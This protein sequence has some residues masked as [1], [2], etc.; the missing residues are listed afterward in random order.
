MKNIPIR[1]I[2]VPFLA[3]NIMLAPAL[4]REP[5]GL[6]HLPPLTV[7]ATPD[8]V[9][10]IN[11]INS[12]SQTFYRDMQSGIHPT[13][14][15]NPTV[16][17]LQR[18][19]TSNCQTP[20]PVRIHNGEK[21]H[22]EVAFT[23]PWEMP[24]NY[25][26]IYYSQ[27]K[28]INI[29]NDLR[30]YLSTTSYGKK[31][32]DNYSV[33]LRDAAI[34]AY[35][36]K[37]QLTRQLPDGSFSP[38][39]ELRSFE[40]VSDPYTMPNGDVE[41]YSI[42]KI[43]NGILMH[44]GIL[45]SRKNLYGIGWEQTTNSA[46][47][48]TS[49]THTNGK[50]IQTKRIDSS[51]TQV[52]DP[53]G[54]NYT[55]KWD[56]ARLTQ[57][58]YPN[59][60]GNKTYHYGENGAGENILTGISID[61]KRFTTYLYNGD[62][63]IQSGR[64]DGSQTYKLQYGSNYTIVTNPLGAVSK[65]I[66]SNNNKDKLTKIERSGV[67]N[68]PNSSAV[69]NYDNKG[70]VISEVDW[71]GVEIIYQRDANGL[72]LQK[73]IPAN[74][75]ATRYTW[76]NSPYLISKVEN[77]ENNNVVSDSVY[78][79]YSSSD[80]AKNR[81]R[82]IK[83]CSKKGVNTCSTIGYG[84]TLHSNGMLKDVAIN[85]DGKTTTYN[86]DAIGNLIQYKN[87]LGHITKYSDY[88][89]LGNVGKVTDPNGL[90][91]EYSYDA[92]SRVISKKEVLA[93]NQ[94]R[95]TIYRYGAFGII[96]TETNGMRETINYNDSGTVA[97]ITHGVGSSIVSGQ[98]YTY[99]NLGKLLSV[100]YR[101]GNNS[102]FSQSN[103]HN[104]L[105]WITADKGN[106]GQNIRYEYDR[107]GNVIKQTDSLGKITT[108]S[109][110]SQNN[111]TQEKRP[112][113]ITIIN[114]YNQAGNL[115]SVKDGKGNTT[116]YTYDGFGNLLTETN[117]DRGTTKYEYD[118]EGSLTKLTRANNVVTTY[119]YDTLNRRT[120]SQT[121]TEIQTWVYDSCTNGKGRLCGTSDG[122]TSKGYGYT[123]D[124]QLSVQTSKIGD[125]N[126]PVYWTYD[127]QGRMI[128]ESRASDSFKVS[129]AYDSLSRV[130]DVKVRISGVEQTVVS[131][132]QYEPYGGIKNWTYGNGLTRQ[133][134]YDKDY[135]LISINTP[136]IQNLTHSYN[137]NNWVTRITDTLDSKRTTSNTYD[138]L[139]QLTQAASTQYTESWNFDNNGNRTN[140]L[141]NTNLTT[142]YQ[143]TTGN[144]LA[145][146]TTTEAKNF[147]YNTL[148][149]LTKKT[150]HSGT[151]DYTYDGFNRLKTV[152]AGSN[153]T[154]YDYDANNL[155][156]RKTNGDGITAYVYAPDGRLLSETSKAATQQG[157]AGT[158]YIWLDGEIIG[159]VRS[160][161]LNF[162]HNDHLGRPDILTDSTKK[163]VW[164]SQNTS[165]DSNVIQSSIGAFN[166]GFP[167]QYYDVES[168]L[169]YNWNRY[170]DASIGRYT[171]SDPIGLAGGLNTYAYVGNNPISFV[172]EQ[173]NVGIPGAAYGALAGA[174]GGGITGGWKGILP[175]ALAGGMVGFLMPGTSHVV[176]AAIGAG[177]ASLVGQGIGN[178][179]SGKDITARKNYDLSAVAGAA[180]GGAA[181]GPINHAIGRYGPHYRVNVIGKPLGTSGI[182]RTP[183][184]LLGATAE[185]VIV[186]TGEY[187][188]SC[189]P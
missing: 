141:G 39:S 138:V 113:G 170:Y 164:K 71:N 57:L 179:I 42:N 99:S 4:A 35:Q 90:V 20:N 55:Y 50:V 187:V 133:S 43:R 19:M 188:G 118:V 75:S 149:N 172:D 180:I 45:T 84:Y 31:W 17:I 61:G 3:V 140:R 77:L 127:N 131:N 165:Y 125:V 151:V 169:W 24:L 67:S 158:V 29:V 10:D 115:L 22:E 160:S 152:K 34:Y 186:G 66:Y 185:G 109:Y 89:G 189:M 73:R 137:A 27:D 88:D 183:G 184:M 130:N 58:I 136:N 2:F 79:Y 163:V 5:V 147:S 54:N 26:R 52:T 117:S 148:G 105:G 76:L 23:T 41:T 60:L 30:M 82:S 51:T 91:I 119:T 8:P 175:G 124:G 153:T 159:M 72:L 108:Y 167:G 102:R 106:N 95:S 143:T 111:L 156:S 155:R 9:L 126:Y 38:I 97:S 177:T 161:K 81:I 13:Y 44:Y 78:T 135:R 150:G 53:A 85:K 128:G 142:N 171:Q 28:T 154:S 107:N 129:Y 116:T 65:Y 92:R 94:I 33:V 1:K 56:G 49:I 16:S 98:Y 40:R 25:S 181:G 173:G 12:L 74:N 101:E 32:A 178:E 122:V 15:S 87:V 36:N 96:Q 69:T 103:T 121:G 100:E 110:D 18:G 6:I 80:P 62:K 93:S 37:V 174:I 14:N 134:N 104:Q 63:A 123:T 132:I 48:V 146:T 176:G 145:S 21:L 59:N 64:S 112:D 86:Y 157:G 47:G 114:S 166:I 162:V 168:N 11:H 120:K 70:Y 144:R 139:G 46:T 68:C 182:N 83:S 7:Y